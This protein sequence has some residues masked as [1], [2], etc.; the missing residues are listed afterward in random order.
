[1]LN[2]WPSD[3]SHGFSSHHRF[4]RRDSRVDLGGT[5]G[6]AARRPVDEMD[7]GPVGTTHTRSTV[8]RDRSRTGVLSLSMTL[9]AT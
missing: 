3:A 7:L 8:A 4:I 6:G 9:H 1:M 5:C 2:A